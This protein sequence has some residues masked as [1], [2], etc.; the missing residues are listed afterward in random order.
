MKRLSYPIR[1]K[2]FQR[3]GDNYVKASCCSLQGHRPSMEDRHVMK[4]NIPKHS[5][6]HLFGIFDGHHGEGAA[7]YLA[8]NIAN[9][10]GKLD[11]LNDP[12]MIQD[13]IMNMDREFCKK[14]KLDEGSCLVFVL[15]KPIFASQ[16]GQPNDQ[17]SNI[18][19]NEPSSYQVSVFW[20]GDSRCLW[21]SPDK[22]KSKGLT[23]DHLPSNPQ[24]R[25]R[26]EN[27]EGSVE[28]GRVDARLAM[29]RAFGDQSLKQNEN[30]PFDK[31]KV[32]A[33]CDYQTFTARPGDWLLLFCDGLVEN[34]TNEEVVEKLKQHISNAEDPAHGLG[35]L[36]DEILNAG[37]RDNMSACLIQLQNGVD[38]GIGV[39]NKTFLPG[40]LYTMKHD[41]DFVRAYM[42]NAGNYGYTD[43]PRLRIAAY[44]EDINFLRRFGRNDP[45]YLRMIGEIENSIGEL[46]SSLQPDDD[47][48]RNML[49]F[50]DQRAIKDRGQDNVNMIDR[51]T[52]IAKS[53]SRNETTTTENNGP[54]SKK[55]KITLDQWVFS[56]RI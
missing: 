51:D 47:W 34:W 17:S 27:A 37:S 38:H 4:L 32:V 49:T 18:T 1:S 29:S 54:T 3:A 53:Y 10:L 14:N 52:N 33:L 39:K 42:E 36:F 50:N 24:E 2:F 6:Y 5:D 45:E 56:R 26:I 12:K 30:K 7:Q 15:V 48:D 43:T 9:E 20:A 28:R 21:L 23:Q 13:C 55:R 11:N 25:Q 8:D 19:S 16:S 41:P 22:D 35:H 44:Q 31:Q 40:P 46:R